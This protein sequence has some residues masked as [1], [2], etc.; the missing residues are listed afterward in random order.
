MAASKTQVPSIESRMA[1]SAALKWRCI[2]PSRG[3]RVVA[4]AGDYSDPM[5]FYFGACAGGIWKTDDGGTYWECVSDGFLT[6]GTIGALTVA[7]SDSNVIYAGTGET[8]IRVDV[9]FGDG[10]YRST[11]AGRSWQHL[12]L[13]KTRQIG[14]IR[15]H[16][17]N[18]DLVYVAALGDAF[19]PS[20][21]RGIYRSADGGKTWQAVLQVDADSGAIDLSMDPTN[22]RVLFA[23]FWQA[24]RQ[25]WNLSSGGPGCRIF[26]SMDGGD[27]W[28][29]VTGAPGFATGMLGKMGV[30]VSPA[31]QGRV[32]ALVEADEHNTGLYRS[33]DYGNSWARITPNR[34]LIHRPWYYTHVFADPQDAD[35]VY[36]TNYQM[37]KSTDGGAS[38]AEVTT[39]HGDNHDLWIDPASPNR[40]VQGNDGGA[41][42]SFNGGRTWSSIYNQPTSQFYRMDVDNQYPYRVYAT[43]QDNTSVSVPSQTEWGMI[44][45]SDLQLPG[46]GE[47]GFIAVHPD[48][49]DI[50]F[51]GAVGSSPGGNGALQRYDKRTRQVQLVNVWPEEATGFA[52]RDLRYRFAWTYPICFSPHDSNTLY[53]GGNHLFRSQDQGNSWECISPDLSH[54]DTSKL[55]YSGGPLTGDSAGAEAYASLSSVAESPHRKGEIWGATDDGRV[56]VT[57]DSGASWTEVTPPKMPA[58]AYIGTVEISQHDADCIYLSATCYKSADYR[59]YLFV[60]RD[61]GASWS[62]ISDSFPQDEITRVIRADTVRQGLLFAGTET[63]V[64][65]SADDGAGWTRMQG[66]FPVTPVYDMRVKHGDLIVATHGRSF[67]IL[68][69]LSPLRAAGSGLIPPRETVR[70]CLSWSTGLFDGDGKDYS[71]A[72]G[73]EGASYKVKNP[74]GRS[75]RRYLDVGENPPDGAILFYWLDES[76]EDNL[77]IEV[78]DSDGA[79]QARFDVSDERLKIDMKPTAHAGLNRFVWDLRSMPPVR[80]DRSLQDRPYQPFA[81]EGDGPAG[82]RVVPG[83]YRV[84]LTAGGKTSTHDLVVA[85]DPR[86]D[87]SDA[88]LAAQYKV[89]KALTDSVSDLYIGV[90]RIRMM[91][92]Q[93]TNLKLLV[94]SIDSQ[95][96]EAMTRLGEIEAR[97]VDVHRETPRDVLRHPA[98]LDDTLMDLRWTALI[99]DA[100]P[101]LQVAELTDIV[102]GDVQSL[103]DELD[104]LVEGPRAALNATVAEIGAPAVS[105]AA[106]GAPKTGW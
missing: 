17:D 48:D 16:P 8:T 5:T 81:R 6:S 36:V 27:S 2:G 98:G 92:K 42:V 34:D 55:D 43:Q 67:W 44:T 32:F 57:R 26:R 91:R 78:H 102:T 82:V 64:F 53:A 4:V 61:S 29:D 52:P 79:L 60:S 14:E 100:K 59:P 84:S 49:P 13:E 20:E 28:Q 15:V 30:S 45:K 63:G 1:E 7:P 77:L 68:D 65:V 47:S 9:S 72:F 74:D 35:T 96:E 40:M 11:D 88:D 25:F 103:L 99:A 104:T 24:R 56:H 106:V 105:A 70:Q 69:D 89:A 93:L 101:P 58:L 73:V 46:T 22:P 10:V 50:V 3:G 38:F 71:P 90:N 18:P 62:S 94:P 83:T 66:G 75:Q 51:V 12:G 37:W 54:N 41:N 39:P 23:T 76:A 86:I 95:I 31:K 97:L 19:G 87:V 33:E 80:L 85:R 21:E